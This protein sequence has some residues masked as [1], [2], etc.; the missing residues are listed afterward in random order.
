MTTE[1]K[2]TQ[3][4]AAPDPHLAT[5]DTD[6]V[7]AGIAPRPP[8]SVTRNMRQCV[9]TRESLP[10]HELLRF[11]IDP[12]GHVTPD[13]NHKL[14]GRGIWVRFDSQAITT[15]LGNPALFQRACKDKTVKIPDDIRTRITTQI[16]A[17]IYATLG[18]LRRSGQLSWGF[19]TVMAEMRRKRP[20]VY[21]TTA[22]EAT[23][24]R[25]KIEHAMGEKTP[26]RILM[27]Q[28]QV[29]RVINGENTTHIIAKSGDLC[30][31]LLQHIDNQKTISG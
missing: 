27:D 28:N 22:Q 29:D 24:S 20:G 25:R 23:D 18:F 1:P 31:N 16:N 15:A 10:Q 14:P 7:G 11:V 12:S 3:H 30:L 17:Q 19:E 8:L 26:M 4:E 5:Q 2:K 6:G 9:V 13:Y 21:L